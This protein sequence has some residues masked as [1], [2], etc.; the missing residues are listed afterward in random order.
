MQNQFYRVKQ[1]ADILGMSAVTVW[2]K[3][4]TDPQFPKPVKVSNAITAW[5]SE[6]VQ[7]YRDALIALS[8]RA[9]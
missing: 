6:E 8:R 3:A 5:P 4:K 2:R 1:V 9:A 7:A